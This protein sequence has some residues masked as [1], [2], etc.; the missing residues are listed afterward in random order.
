MF[1]LILQGYYAP[2]LALFRYLTLFDVYCKNHRLGKD[3]GRKPLVWPHP[4]YTVAIPQ[5]ILVPEC[6]NSGFFRYAGTC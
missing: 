5:A 4:L 3:S 1:F 6:L 2:Y